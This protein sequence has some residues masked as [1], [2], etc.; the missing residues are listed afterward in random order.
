MSDAGRSVFDFLVNEA[1]NDVAYI[2]VD[3]AVFNA[4]DGEDVEL[5]SQEFTALAHF[6]ASPD[7][8][9]ALLATGGPTDPE[10]LMFDILDRSWRPLPPGI[11][12]ATWGFGPDRIVAQIA[13]ANGAMELDEIDVSKSSFPRTTL[14]P[15]FNLLGVALRAVPPDTIYATEK[16]SAKSDGRIWSFNTKTGLLSLAIAPT[17]GLMAAI[18]RSGNVGFLSSSPREFHI[19][20]FSSGMRDVVGVPFATFPQKCA[21]SASTT[22]CFAPAR[23]TGLLK[24]LSLPDDWL[25]GAAISTDALYRTDLGGGETDMIFASGESGVPAMDAIRV[26]TARGGVYALNRRDHA[27]YKITFAPLPL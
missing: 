6:E 3:G 26:E 17:S 10:W 8:R 2:T 27:L 5:S 15:R 14:A 19:M 4:A 23:F 7:R 22:Y 1:T 16:P 21:A 18:P 20:T 24:S 25:S 11:R 9:R 12:A 13:D